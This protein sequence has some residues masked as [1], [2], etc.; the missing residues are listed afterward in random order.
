MQKVNIFFAVRWILLGL[1]IGA[2]PAGGTES[3]EAK[4]QPLFGVALKEPFPLAKETFEE[5]K[6]LILTNYY[7]SELKEE[8][9]YWAAIQGMLR[10]ISPP[11]NPDLAKLWTAAE[12]ESILQSLEGVSVS[13]GIKSSFNT[14]DGSLTVTEVEEKSP[15]EGILQPLDRIL[16]IDGQVLKGKSIAEIN[17]LLNGEEY[18]DVVLTV[19]RDIKIFDIKLTR[20]KFQNENLHPYRISSNMGLLVLDYF[21]QDISL[22]LEKVLAEWKA[23]GIQSII[24]DLRNNSGGVFAEALK[25]CHLFV[26]ERGIVLR[27]YNQQEKLRH[28]ASGNAAPFD[29]R[30]AVLVNGN[31]A[32]AA[33]VVVGALRD[34]NKAI[35]VGSKTFGKGVFEKT[36]E[37]K[38]HYRVKF[39]TGAMYTPKGMA[40]QG[41]GFIPD[42]FVEQEAGS[43]QTYRKL[44]IN[45]RL[46]KD[47]ALITAVKLLQLAAPRE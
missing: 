20:V 8:T 33:E 28:Y 31:T 46:Q 41:K 37:L 30:M 24:L 3:M 36:F 27:T 9:L 25:V 19:V 5:V 23:S 14:N 12:Y 29:F 1:L 7:I 35:L 11:D 38:N 22:N 21:S 13:L 16:R 4:I 18:S 15:A 39:I 26:P 40:W 17:Q 47:V 6:E 43:L 44:D 45:T 32:S 34:Q 42:Y 10:H 2:I